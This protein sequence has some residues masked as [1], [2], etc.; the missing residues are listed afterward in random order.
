MSAD[1]FHT[2]GPKFVWEKSLCVGR[3][4]AY[5]QER[6]A[7]DPILVTDQECVLYSLSAITAN[8]TA[9]AGSYKQAS[10]HAAVTVTHRSCL[11]FFDDNVRVEQ[12]PGG[13]RCCWLLP[14]AARGG[15]GLLCTTSASPLLPLLTQ[16]EP[17]SCST[18]FLFCCAAARLFFKRLL[19]A[20]VP[21]PTCAFCS[22]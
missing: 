17:A 16:E 12:H 13:L 21:S 7:E 15:R 11:W 14:F 4:K 10:P 3:W 5:R 9:K 22:L 2:V 18:A 20:D 19:A 1:H 6:I 8:I